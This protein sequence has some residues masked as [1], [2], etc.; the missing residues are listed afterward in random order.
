MQN[1]AKELPERTYQYGRRIIA[2]FKA[3]PENKLAQT[4]GLQLLRAGRSAGANYREADR[5]RT[6]AEFVAKMGD[7]LKELDES[8]FWLR[9]I[10]DSELLQPNRLESLRQET[11][12]LIRIFVAIIKKARGE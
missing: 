5:A 9:H 6:K 12:E 4:L 7:S 8:S 11:D 10:R 1:G 3:L 2:L